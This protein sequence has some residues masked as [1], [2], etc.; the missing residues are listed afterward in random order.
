M[1]KWATLE[2]Q[3]YLVELWARYGNQ[4]L[5]GHSCCPELS[6][7]YRDGR[8][9][10]RLYDVKSEAAIDGWIEDDREQ[11]Q[12]DWER[13]RARM[14]ALHEPRGR[15][16]GRFTGVSKDI[17]RSSQPLYYIEAIGIS[18]LTFTPFAKVRLASSHTRLLIP[19][20]DTLKGVSKNA[21]RKA[22]RYGKRLPATVET[23]I[24]RIVGNAI[25]DYWKAEI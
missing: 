10:G 19:V 24:S 12:A 3:K 5:K 25:S 6:H 2:R 1:P 21:R 9:A 20:G 7:Y 23:A 4:C 15:V 11:S 8:L 13:E 16:S 17:W 14:H 22:R 18:G